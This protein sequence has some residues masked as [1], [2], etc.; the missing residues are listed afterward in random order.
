MIAHVEQFSTL[1]CSQADTSSFHR[2]WLRSPCWPTLSPHFIITLTNLLKGIMCPRAHK[3]W[4]QFAYNW[5]EKPVKTIFG[6]NR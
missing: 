5:L 6:K 4:H 3:T 2:S 1:F